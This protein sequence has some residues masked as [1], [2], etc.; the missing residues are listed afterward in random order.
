MGRCPEPAGLAPTPLCSADGCAAAPTPTA[1]RRHRQLR[2]DTDGC[3]A[4]PTARGD[5]RWLRGGCIRR[6]LRGDTNGCAATPTAAGQHSRRGVRPSLLPPPCFFRPPSISSN[7]GPR[8]PAGG[9]QRRS[10]LRSHKVSP[11]FNRTTKGRSKDSPTPLSD[12]LGHARTA[13][14]R[15]ISSQTPK[16]NPSICLFLES[17]VLYIYSYYLSNN[18]NIIK[19]ERRP[20][21]LG[22]VGRRWS[23]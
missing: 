9:L 12:T 23:V 3:G 5:A 13:E 16:P 1:A 7:V 10:H 4:T 20:G 17:A 15:P 18:N 14:E 22:C 19:I 8:G 11:V 21:D 6:R 2:S